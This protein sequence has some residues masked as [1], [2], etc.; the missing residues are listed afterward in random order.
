MFFP[1]SR[2]E[3]RIVG[4]LRDRE[5]ACS[6]LRP[7][8][9]SGRQCH[10]THLIIF[11]RFSWPSLAYIC[12]QMWLKARFISFFLLISVGY[13]SK[14]SHP[15][16]IAVLWSGWSLKVLFLLFDLFLFPAGDMACHG[17]IMEHFRIYF[18]IKSHSTSDDQVIS[19]GAYY[20]AYQSAHKHDKRAVVWGGGYEIVKL[21]AVLLQL[22]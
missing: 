1:H 7:N 10:L 12:A 19:I 17:T 9:V 18:T 6:G 3:V 5:V 13:T 11:R 2:V 4:S 20:L 14:Y 22:Q 8:P 16:C 21:R 15:L